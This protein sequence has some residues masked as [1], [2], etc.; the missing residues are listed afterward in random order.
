[1]RA[2]GRFGRDGTLARPTPMSR[3][4]ASKSG[5]P[6]TC[7]APASTNSPFENGFRKVRIRPPGRSSASRTR[8]SRP[9]FDRPWATARPESPPPTITMRRVGLCPGFRRELSEQA[10]AAAERA[11]RRAARRRIIRF[12]RWSR[13]SVTRTGRGRGSFE[14]AVLPPPDPEY[15]RLELP[16]ADGHADELILRL[17]RLRISREM[18]VE[19]SGRHRLE[20]E[21]TG[22][23]RPRAAAGNRASEPHVREW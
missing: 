16:D 22:R 1:M 10:L 7:L 9:S 20:Y 4:K 12:Q 21:E 2:S 17:Y 6:T 8:T 3:M 18:D 19:R 15:S 5:S 13:I 23:V 14:R 11:A